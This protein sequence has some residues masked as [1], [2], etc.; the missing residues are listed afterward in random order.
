MKNIGLFILSLVVFSSCSSG[1]DEGSNDPSPKPVE[2]TSPTIPGLSYPTNNIVCINNTINFQWNAAIDTQNDA[3]TYQLQI[4]TDNAFTQNLNSSV[5]TVLSKQ[6]ALIKG[7]S[8]YWRVKAIDAK[9]ASS[10][11]SATYNFYT[12]GEGVI[13][14]VPFAPVLVTPALN[15]VQTNTTVNLSWT[16]VDADVNDVLTYD[17][18]FG[19]SNSLTNK[20]ATAITAKTFSV[21]TTTATNYYWKVVVNDGKGGTTVGQIWNFKTN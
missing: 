4:A 14:H 15:S 9:N 21:N 10:N 19:T 17:V 20:V 2:N 5:V 7:K 1:G 18:Y 6:I 3:I 12:E 13:N 11:Y 16:A 8:Y